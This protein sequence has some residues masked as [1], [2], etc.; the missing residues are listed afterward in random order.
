MCARGFDSG[1]ALAAGEMPSKGCKRGALQLTNAGQTCN[2]RPLKIYLRFKGCQHVPFVCAQLS[3]RNQ[4]ISIKLRHRNHTEFFSDFSLF[5]QLIAH[6]GLIMKN[7]I[8]WIH[9]GEIMKVD[10]FKFVIHSKNVTT[11]TVRRP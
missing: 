11:G 5:G 10:F 9:W 8:I 6:A 4:A 1:R 2:K 7:F 3:C